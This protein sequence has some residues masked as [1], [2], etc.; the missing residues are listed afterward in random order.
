ML[1]LEG[2]ALCKDWKGEKRSEALGENAKQRRKP[3]RR[4]TRSR[5][6]VVVS[7][8]GGAKNAIGNNLEK[9]CRASQ[10]G[11]RREKKGGGVKNT[12]QG[13]FRSEEA[14]RKNSSIVGG[15]RGSSKRKKDAGR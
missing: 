6:I 10:T 12:F 14:H 7:K 5:E 13:S 11:K 8:K 4:K 3:T 1:I 9:A 2:G 15:I